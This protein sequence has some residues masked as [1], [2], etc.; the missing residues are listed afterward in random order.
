MEYPWRSRSPPANLCP[1]C[2][3]SHF[4]FCTPPPPQYFR[5]PP[6]PPNQFFR[7]PLPPPPHQASYDPFVDHQGGPAVTPYPPPP[8]AQIPPGPWNSDPNYSSEYYRNPNSGPDREIPSQIG[9]KRMRFDNGS[10]GYVGS[11]EEDER[12]LKLIRDHGAVSGGLDRKYDGGCSVSDRSHEPSNFQGIE[13][14]YHKENNHSV[15]QNRP[16]HNQNKSSVMHNHYG[17]SPGADGYRNFRPPRGNHETLAYD[18][19]SYQDHRRNFPTESREYNNQYLLPHAKQQHRMEP[20]LPYYGL[21]N[22]G[23]NKRLMQD[24]PGFMAQPPLPTSPPPPIPV[25]PSRFPFR[26]GVNSAS[27]FHSPYSM[28]SESVTSVSS[29]YTSKGYPNSSGYHPEVCYL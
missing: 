18:D 15:N 23:E 9:V 21:S 17:S 25:E 2:S 16:L 4:P 27:S 13:S 1:I 6:P 26:G 20:Q 12:R 11:F 5:P 29:H 3:H 8:P 28:V 24:A 22:Q 10:D 14:G 7:S 19:S